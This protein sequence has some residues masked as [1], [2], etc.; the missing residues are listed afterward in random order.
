MKVDDGIFPG[1]KQSLLIE[2]VYT[3][4]GRVDI[5]IDRDGFIESVGEGAGRSFRSHADSVIS[6]QDCIAI[7][8]LVNTHTHAAMTLLRG[9]ADD[10]KLEE[11]LSQKIWPLEA[12]LTGEDVYWG[13]LLA[14]LEMIKNGTVAFADMYFFMEDA[15]RAVAKSG[16]KAVLSYGFIDLFDPDKRESEI[17]TTENLVSHIRA[18]QNP[19]I[20]P[21]LGPHAIYTVSQESLQWLSEYSERERVPIHIHLSETEKET[22][23]AVKQ[24]GK[25]PVRILED[26]G[27]LTERT[28]AKHCCWVDRE[29]CALF[30]KRGVSVSH[31]PVSNMKLAVNRAMPYHWLKES[32][33]NVSLGKDGCASNNNLD[34]FEEMKMAAL[35]QKFAWN[36]PTLLPA[37]EAFRMATESGA[38]TLGFGNGTISPG[39][40]ADLVLLDRTAPCNTPMHNLYSNIVYSCSGATVRTVICQGDIL[41]KDRF[42][43]WEEEVIERASAAA[44]DLV[45]R[46]HEG[47]ENI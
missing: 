2:N 33:V 11:W 31:N 38:R 28:L 8:G 23:D 12:N 37:R 18:L 20:K 40:P 24:W 10:L 46:R 41:M 1:Q 17:K 27:M 29:E 35:L 47:Q 14:C 5:C 30:G 39:Q 32:G 19:K 45:R 13:T 7:P 26:C 34:L 44:E 4:G 6:G 3:F 22:V 15:A 25:R 43:P 36:Q 9:Y 42:I 16:L 21:A